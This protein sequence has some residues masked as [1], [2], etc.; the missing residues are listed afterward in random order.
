[1]A[2]VEIWWP[3]S[4]SFHDALCKRPWILPR[5]IRETPIIQRYKK[6][7][8]VSDLHSKRGN[9]MLQCTHSLIKAGCH[10][11]GNWNKQDVKFTLHVRLCTT[12]YGWT[13]D[14][15][16]QHD[17]IEL[18]NSL[19][20]TSTLAAICYWRAFLRHMNNVALTTITNCITIWGSR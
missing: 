15:L 17:W 16:S 1:M 6:S 9:C 11:S 8:T 10:V 5:N 18:C 13:H 4:T 7:F 14:K 12:Q 3:H 20:E 19:L 2:D